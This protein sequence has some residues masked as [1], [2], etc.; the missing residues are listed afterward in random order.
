[1]NAS[2][3]QCTSVREEA[4]AILSRLD[5]PESAFGRGGVPATSPITGESLPTSKSPAGTSP[6]HGN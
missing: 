6:R 3:I 2:P 1:M 5:V 4:L